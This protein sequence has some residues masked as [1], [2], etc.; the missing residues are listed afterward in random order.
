MLIPIMLLVSFYLGGAVSRILTF[1][2]NCQENGFY[3]DTKFDETSLFVRV[4]W[5]Y[6]VVIRGL[7]W[8]L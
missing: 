7:K 6:Y 3:T 5:W 1:H 8:P 2:R 4:R